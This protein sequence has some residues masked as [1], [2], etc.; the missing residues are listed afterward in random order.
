MI[1]YEMRV[2]RNN[3]WDPW[4]PA[5]GFSSHLHDNKYITDV[6]YTYEDGTQIEYRRKE[7]PNA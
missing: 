1:V 7:V 2:S 6:I 3:I 4:S 5:P